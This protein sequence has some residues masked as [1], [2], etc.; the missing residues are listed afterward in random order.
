VSITYE[1]LI[2]P[3][4]IS[5]FTFE[6]RESQIHYSIVMFTQRLAP[7]TGPWN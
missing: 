2:A 5:L 4:Y 1:L 3:H 6:G 7:P